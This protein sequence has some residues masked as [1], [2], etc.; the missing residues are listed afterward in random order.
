MQLEPSLTPAFP[1]S[2][3][4]EVYFRYEDVRYAPSLDEFDNP[5]GEGYTDLICRQFAVT[6][7]TPKGAWLDVFGSPKFVRLAANKRYACP[8]KEEAAAS[9]VA[10]KKAQVRIYEGRAKAA[11]KALHLGE[12]LFPPT[13]SSP[14]AVGL[15]L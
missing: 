5:I 14:S 15:T 11:R 13:A 10:R 8:T 1:K 12:M 9:F 2:P 4:A 3:E 7:R 6:K